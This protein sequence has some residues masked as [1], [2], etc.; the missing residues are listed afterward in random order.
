MSTDA[1]AELRLI[2]LKARLEALESTAIPLIKGE[3][4]G[5]PF[6]GNQYTDGSA[7]DPPAT[8]RM[9]RNALRAGVPGA[10]AMSVTPMAREGRYDIRVPPRYRQ[11][12]Y[13]AV[14]R[15]NDHLLAAGLDVTQIS[16]DRDRRGGVRYVADVHRPR[17]AANRGGGHM[18]EEG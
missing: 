8:A 15:I 18:H 17:G 9:V 11:D 10:L 3:S 4:E 14:A 7:G 5:H 1:L 16:I 12:R 13:S 6:R 2:F